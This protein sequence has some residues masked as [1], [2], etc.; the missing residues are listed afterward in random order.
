M[1]C[2]TGMSDEEGSADQNEL[3]ASSG[4]PLLGKTY[5]AKFTR[6]TQVKNNAR[7]FRLAIRL[8]QGS[9]AWRLLR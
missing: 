6:Q 1:R 5:S 9:P 7:W 3:V 4:Q 2:V 8:G